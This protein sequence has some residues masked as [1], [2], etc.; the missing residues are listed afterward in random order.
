MDV[1]VSP[2]FLIT[3]QI[4]SWVLPLTLGSVVLERR[5]DAGNVG[6]IQLSRRSP[7]FALF[8]PAGIRRSRSALCEIRN[9]KP[10][11]TEGGVA[12]RCIELVERRKMRL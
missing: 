6:F 11:R 1:V 12:W 2:L 9:E 7:R 8:S 10:A 3:N 4:G 5:G